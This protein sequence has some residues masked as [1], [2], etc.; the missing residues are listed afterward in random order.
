MVAQK[1]VEPP[2]IWRLTGNRWTALNAEIFPGSKPIPLPARSSFER[3]DSDTTAAQLLHKIRRTLVW[4]PP[5]PVQPV[6]PALA[7]ITSRSSG[8]ACVATFE[9]PAENTRA[10]RPDREPSESISRLLHQAGSEKKKKGRPRFV[11]WLRH[12]IGQLCQGRISI[13]A[14]VVDEGHQ[15]RR[16]AFVRRVGAVWVHGFEVKGRVFEGVRLVA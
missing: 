14:L 7:G 6:V 4:T 8:R 1:A 16:R 12:Q 3:W 10:S 11:L 9:T 2:L 5:A 15:L 13:L